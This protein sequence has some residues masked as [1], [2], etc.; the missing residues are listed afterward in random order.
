MAEEDAPAAALAVAAAAGRG[1]VVLINDKLRLPWT[2]D[3]EAVLRRG[4]AAG[5]KASEQAS[6]GKKKRALDKDMM[7]V[8]VGCV[9]WR[10][11]VVW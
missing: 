7:P 4:E 8:F 9:G 2:G 5:T 11:Y 3:E 10:T 1:T 6:K